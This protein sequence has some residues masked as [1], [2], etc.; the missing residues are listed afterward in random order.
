MIETQK[1]SSLY[2]YIKALESGDAAK[3]SSSTTKNLQ[4]RT[5]FVASKDCVSLFL[6]FFWGRKGRW[7]TLIVDKCIRS[8]T[9]AKG[10]TL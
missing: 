8:S 10:S 6:S 2:I 5:H 4:P 9:T 7:F 3:A 1:F